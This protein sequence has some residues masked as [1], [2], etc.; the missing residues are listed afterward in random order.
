MVQP[1]GVKA[2]LGHVINAT[3]LLCRVE[4]FYHILSVSCSISA[5]HLSGDFWDFLVP[6]FGSL[7]C[8]HHIRPLL[9]VVENCKNT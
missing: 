6:T 3:Y 7:S 5:S 1:T 4:V 8:H 2:Y 9:R